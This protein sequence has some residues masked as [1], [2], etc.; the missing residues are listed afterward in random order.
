MLNKLSVK[1]GLI[2]LLVVMTLILLLVS[3]LGA[4][5][6]RQS[7][8]SLQKINQLQGDELGSLADSYSFSLR[9]RV[10]SGVAVRQLEIGMMDD[11]KTTTDRIAGYIKQAD[12]D[13]A[14]FVSI[15][16]ETRQ[17]RDLSDVVKKTYDA[18]KAN[19]LVPLL[20]ALQAQSA[21]GYYDVLENKITPYSNAYDKALADF[22]AYAVDNT[23]KRIE[24]ARTN[25]R[26]QLTVIVAAFIIALIIAVL[27][28]F[29]LQKIIMHPL[30]FSIAQLEYIAKGDLT[31]EIDDSR[32]NEM[33][34]LLKAM[35]QMQDSLVES[36][37]RVRDAGNQ[38]DVGSRELAAGNVHLAQ[39]TEESAA[40]LEETAASM[41]QLT[42][43]VRMNAANSEQANQLA[44]SVSVIAGKGSE[45]V[46][47]VMDKMQGI[48][49]SSKR[50]GDIITV[51]D[52]IA[53]QTN[54]LA[55]NAAV[56]A[57]RAGEQGRGFA[58]VAG[59]VR[60]LAQRSAQSAK[61]IKE[62]I[63]D[64][65]SRVSEGSDMVKSA[66]DTMLE[67]SS[68]VTRVTSLMREISIAT[69]EQT[70]G[71]EQVNVAITQMDQVAQQNAALVEQAT[72][73]T[74]SLEEQAQLLAESMAVFKL[75]RA[76][77]F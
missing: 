19:G 31:H 21:D 54:I 34:R 51:I 58:V 8:T 57:A 30:S 13:L 77:Q 14:K 44:Q 43:T 33:G 55:L 20:A 40:S 56:E 4:N 24:Q 72:A 6:I 28:W 50:I 35:K 18:Y 7:A 46:H 53:F 16:D 49:D 66:A 69:T 2:G 1:A 71:I 76:G 61:E 62:L 37:G 27:A 47:Q 52:G 75:N 63:V 74:R 59:E 70:H 22:R 29:A 38:I 11:A 10:A 68:E 48:T 25:A 73:A 15:Q 65:E 60:S 12:N 42:S 45:V 32:N 3:V 36:V 64:S 17:G 41:E 67:I 23:S 5:A 9:T 26:I 39:R